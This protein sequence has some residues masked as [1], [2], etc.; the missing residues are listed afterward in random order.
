MTAVSQRFE[1]EFL[2]KEQV[3]KET[4]SFFF[5]R[6]AH[7]D[8]L[9][10]QFMRLTL[11]ILQPDERGNSRF[12]SIASSPTEKDYLMITTRSNHS[13]FKKTLFTLAIETK[14][15]IA[16]PYGVFTLKPEETA[17]HVFLAG[18]IGVTPFRS[19]IRYASD[20]GLNIPI[21]LF[22]SFRTVEDVIFQK[23]LREIADRR[24]WFKLVET[25]TQPEKLTSSWQGNLGRIDEQF[26]KKN[27]FNFSSSLFYLAGPPAMVDVMISIVKSLGVD[28]QRI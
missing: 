15:G 19:M 7:L 20:M 17:P 18:G 9:P 12:F 23:E 13:A 21:T 8:F 22:T 25:I 28:D 2:K 3:A 24:S 26:I 14:V 5:K 16:A 1:A 4:S 10:G 27:V 6:P 11:D